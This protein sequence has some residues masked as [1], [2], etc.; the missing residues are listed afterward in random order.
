[1]DGEAFPLPTPAGSGSSVRK[2]RGAI[3]AQ[4][5][6]TCRSRKQKCDEQ[7]PKCGTCQKFKLECNY[8]EPQPTKK[9]KTLVEILE[10]I[11]SLE[12][13]IDR[14]NL[15]PAATF[16]PVPSLVT[17]APLVVS[18][19]LIGTLPATP[20]NVSDGSS[21]ASGGE[22]HY[23][24]AASVQQM[25]E[26]PVLQQLL[27]VL[28]PK[29]GLRPAPLDRDS[30]AFLLGRQAAPALPTDAALEVLGTAHAMRTVAGPIPI[31]A[32]AL[33]W[34]T[35]QQLS[36]AYFDGFNF[37]YPLL[38]R[39]TFTSETMVAV[40]NDGFSDGPA[41]TLTFLVFALGEVALASVGGLPV[42]L[43][44]GRP[45]GFRGGTRERPPGLALF[46]E[47]R[48]RMGFNLT[49]CSLENVQ[50]FALASIYYETCCHHVEFWRMTVS[51]S[52]AC[53]ALIT[54]NPG[55]LVSPR[56]DLIRRVFWHCSIME[57]C[58]HLELGL[59]LTG[60]DKMEPL[61]GLPSFNGPF[62]QDDY[63]G[64]EGSHFQEYFASQIVL[65]RLLVSFHTTLS[66]G[67][68]PPS[69]PGSPPTPGALSCG[70]IGSLNQQLEQWL[71]M[72]PAYLRWQQDTPGAFPDPAP[73]A[74]P[75]A[76]APALMFTTDLDAPPAAYPF[77][78]DVQVA[79]LRSRYYYTK[80]LIHRPF[81]Y[82]A[83]HYPDSLTN[84]ECLGVAACLKAC[85][86]WPI[87]M[88]PTSKHK[89]LVPCVFFWSANLLGIL[90][91][92]H[93][94]R[95]VP[96]L[97]EIRSTLC[98]DRFELDAG[99]SVGLY[100]D[101]L[102]DLK[103]IDASSAWCWDVVQSLYQLDESP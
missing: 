24:Y 47:A 5:C 77:A 38:D 90:V 56:A 13:K 2:E 48:Q 26:W 25:L 71:G 66:N 12:S 102:R 30:P 34:E 27:E 87:A 14:I 3:A 82:K 36:K 97:L 50:I 61:I 17:S 58:L 55:E 91:L 62:S 92:L 29:P 95:G 45:S 28:G 101:W 96:V 76:I 54:S 73:R 20:F 57:T 40:F 19:E 11:R 51:A 89:R 67:S 16:P 35:M 10:R 83:L 88:S 63:L 94:S 21:G 18:P 69:A 59:P 74:H 84:D 78:L 43:Y 31:T 100:I 7:R 75:A 33:G 46:N 60:L 79:L 42:H 70:T 6:D 39:Q 80:Y 93:L 1:M 72:L 8:R 81:V 15:G 44:N 52:L 32:P 23:R 103:S 98:G 99:E 9:D 68:P 4:A 49:D 86:K 53:Q 85:L 37:L 22:D 41:S 65:R 64:N